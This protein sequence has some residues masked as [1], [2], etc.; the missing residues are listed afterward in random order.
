MSNT[1]DK[2]II[3]TF[4]IVNNPYPCYPYMFMTE[5][6]CSKLT[7]MSFWAPALNSPAENCIPKKSLDTSLTTAD[8]HSIKPEF[9]FCTGSYLARSVLEICDGEDV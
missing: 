5:N 4:S 2:C 9:R 7:I 8:L 1:F 3:I 6:C